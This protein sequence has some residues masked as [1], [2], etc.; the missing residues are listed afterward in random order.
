MSFKSP[1]HPEASPGCLEGKKTNKT[2]QNK[3]KQNK[4]K[5]TTRS[6]FHINKAEKDQGSSS[7]QMR[8]EI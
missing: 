4:T 2:K 7:V 1:E 3:T 8:L 6:H 5:Q